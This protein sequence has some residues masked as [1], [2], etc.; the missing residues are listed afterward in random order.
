MILRYFCA[1][2]F[3]AGLPNL[4][5]AG[6]PTAPVAREE[7][8]LLA[9]EVRAIFEAK[10]L[11]CH[12]PEL[13]RPKGRFG[14]VLDLKRVAENPEYVVR[15]EPELSEIYVM[16]RDDEMPGEDA[17]VPPLTPEEKEKVRRWIEIGAPHEAPPAAGSGGGPS[18][19]AGS[20][21]PP[22]EMPFWKRAIRWIGKW[23]PVSTHFPVALMFVAAFA[24]GLAWW[25]RRA[26]WLETVRLLI[27]LA[28]FGALVAAG[29]GWVNAW[30]TS[31]VG[32]AVVIL[33]WHQWLGTFTAI[34]A[35]ICAAL[36]FAGPCTEGSRQRQRFRGALLVGTALVGISGFLGSALIY[37]LDHYA[38]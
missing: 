30:F 19:G 20:E 24:E 34:W 33:Q 18:P 35:T 13:P 2:L 17:N 25:T 38:W 11:D 23:H 28:A 3:A 1:F 10:C 9:A 4:A 16:V 6:A 32:K 7:R 29:L 21:P 14:H 27:V 31:Y 36:S 22:L 37:G 8:L 26:S 5:R 15:G 12:G